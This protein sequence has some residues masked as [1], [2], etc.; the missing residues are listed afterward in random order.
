MRLSEDS[1][2]RGRRD[3]PP[4]GRWMGTMLALEGAW[5]SDVGVDACPARPHHRGVLVSPTAG[6]PLLSPS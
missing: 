2:G 4:K 5:A 1:G 3:H 6:A